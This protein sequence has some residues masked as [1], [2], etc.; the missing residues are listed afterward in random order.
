MVRVDVQ[1]IAGRRTK[2][3]HRCGGEDTQVLVVI[4]RRNVTLLSTCTSSTEFA[5]HYAKHHNMYIKLHCWGVVF[6][7]R[8]LAMFC[9][10]SFTAQVPHGRVPAAV[11]LGAPCSGTTC[12]TCERPM[13]FRTSMIKWISSPSLQVILV[14]LGIEMEFNILCDCM[15]SSPCNMLLGLPRVDSAVNHFVQQDRP[16]ACSVLRHPIAAQIWPA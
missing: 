8:F 3:T 1:R 9:C 10:L 5:L 15:F 4:S 7:S 14:N 2:F 13:A 12:A 11:R 6:F 16:R